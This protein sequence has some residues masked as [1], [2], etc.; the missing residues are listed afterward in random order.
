MRAL[1]SPTSRVHSKATLWHLKASQGMNSDTVRRPL[2]HLAA[3][4]L[5]STRRRVEGAAPRKE[6]PR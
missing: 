1:L 4:L 2:P 6:A 3:A 5:A